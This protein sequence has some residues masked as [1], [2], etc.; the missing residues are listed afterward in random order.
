[1]QAS[2]AIAA[3]IALAACAMAITGA[4]AAARTAPANSGALNRI[5]LSTPAGAKHYLSSIGIDPATV[6]VQR[7]ARNYAGPQCPGNGWNC[8]SARRVVQISAPAKGVRR[9]L[10]ATA[11]NSFEC[12]PATSTTDS[13][14]CV[15]VQTGSVNKARCVEKS[16]APNAALSCVIDQSGTD[17]DAYV[18]QDISTGGSTTSGSV[19]T[20]N[21]SETA[22][23]TQK[24]VNNRLDATQVVNQSLNASTIVSGSITQSQDDAQTIIVCQGGSGDCHAS[25]GG[26]NIS[27]IHQSRFAKAHASGG[28]IVQS[29]DT[30]PNG[31]CD[32][33]NPPSQPNLCALVEQNSTTSNDSDLHQ[34]DHLQAVAT[35]TLGANVT[36]KQQQ[37]TDGIDAHVPQP[38]IGTAVNKN[39][40]HQH[41]TDDMSAPAGAN[42]SQDPG[43]GCCSGQGGNGQSHLDGHSVGI[44]R[45]SEKNASQELAIDDNCVSNGSCLLLSHGKIN[46]SQ[47][48]DRCSDQAG[49]SPAFCTTHVFC[50]SETG[51][52]TVIPDSV[53]L[54]S[55]GFDALDF[56]YAIN[57][58]FPLT[59]PVSPL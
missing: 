48:T 52:T 8:T 21:N 10:A 54:A 36:Q 55:L 18:L 37:P 34:E 42:Q 33:F 40:V 26:N 27:K 9:T 1:M 58:V 32:P 35:G 29:Q 19:Q 49:E 22:T 30:T 2:R 39:V 13:T 23:V 5:D 50:D 59:L 17:N 25:N 15:I 24:G 38:T 12:T 53:D 43:L 47:A 16:D 56:Q 14:G 44:L 4:G 6:V 7:G 20:Q 11:A 46:G 51:C 28:T 57:F 31:D 41:L 3:A 45:A